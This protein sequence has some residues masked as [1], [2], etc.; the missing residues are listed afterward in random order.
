MKKLFSIELVHSVTGVKMAGTFAC[1]VCKREYLKDH[2]AWVETW[3]TS[4]V[5]TK[6]RKRIA[7]SSVKQ[8]A[9]LNSLLL[10]VEAFGKFVPEDEEQIWVDRAGVSSWIL[11]PRT[12]EISWGHDFF[13]TLV[14]VGREKEMRL[15]KKINS[16][17]KLSRKGKEG[18]K[19]AASRLR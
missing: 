17:R 3:T 1:P 2:R 5:I 18:E 6:D 14:K 7:S 12:L 8:V 4:Y 10:A 15:L 11:I 13:A 19:Q 9:W 16:K